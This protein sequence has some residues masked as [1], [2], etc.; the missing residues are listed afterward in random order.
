MKQYV[1]FLGALIFPLWAHSL[2]LSIISVDYEDKLIRINIEI[3]SEVV[4]YIPENALQPIITTSTRLNGF[5]EPYPIFDAFLM[6]SRNSLN[7]FT[8][9][10]G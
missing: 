7:G 2:E 3:T 9:I 1:F 10:P 8:F 5:G 4:V 6:P